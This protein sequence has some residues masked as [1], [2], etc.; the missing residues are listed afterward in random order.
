[1]ATVTLTGDPFTNW[2]TLV[3]VPFQQGAQATVSDVISALQGPVTA[4]VV[5]FIIVSGILVMRGDLG[6]RNGITRIISVSLVVALVLSV[7]NYNEYITSFFTQGLP[8]FF[9]TATSGGTATTGPATFFQFLVKI[10]T[11]FVTA[12]KGVSSVNLVGSVILGVLNVLA[13][14]PVTILFLFYELTEVLIEV[15]V[16]IGPFVL[17]GYLF[18]ATRSVADRFIGKLIGL[19]LLIL[20]VDIMLA[21]IDNAINVYCAGVLASITSGQTSTWFGTFEN[22]AATTIVCIQLVVF[23]FICV[24]VMAFIPGIASYIGGGISVSPLTAAQSISN[25]VTLVSGGGAAAPAAAASGGSSTVGGGSGNSSS[26][27]SRGSG[28]PAVPIPG[29]R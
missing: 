4:L 13:L 20:L 27:G 18:A 26:R 7:E 10:Q 12:E 6:V 15:V 25:A 23:L 14:I 19:S 17:P 22:V 16:C 8:S 2:D 21:I 5:L 29:Q 28:A 3:Q 11:I 24:L 9:A 1:M